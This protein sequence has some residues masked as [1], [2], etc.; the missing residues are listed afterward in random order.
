VAFVAVINGSTGTVDLV[1]DVMGYFVGSS[2]RGGR[3]GDSPPES[4]QR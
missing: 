2:S 3:E 4:D 1:V